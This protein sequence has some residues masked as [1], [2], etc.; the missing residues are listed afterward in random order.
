MSG[1]FFSRLK[2]KKNKPEEQIPQEDKPKVVNGY[3][4]TSNTR[5]IRPEYS[6]VRPKSAGVIKPD[7]KKED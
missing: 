6:N 1:G 5:V 3:L 4:Q 2:G 7:E